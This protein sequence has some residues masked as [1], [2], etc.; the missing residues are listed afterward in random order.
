MRYLSHTIVKVYLEARQLENTT[1]LVALSLDRNNISNKISPTAHLNRI[2]YTNLQTNKTI[3][4][5]AYDEHTQYLSE[6]LNQLLGLY[7]DKT[8]EVRWLDYLAGQKRAEEA[9]NILL[10]G[11]KKY[12]KARRKKK[13]TSFCPQ[14]V[15]KFKIIHNNKC[16]SKVVLP[17]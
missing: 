3:G 8:G 17:S 14:F 13:V 7:S 12:N 2:G 11:G 10:H 15:L 16:L 6:N 9:C 1:P 4:T 5:T